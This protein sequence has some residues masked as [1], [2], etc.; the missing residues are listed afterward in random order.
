MH[1]YA[2]PC[3]FCRLTWGRVAVV[4]THPAANADVPRRS[5]QS[6]RVPAE[7]LE[8]C[9]RSR[10]LWA[11]MGLVMASEPQAQH[12][13]G[14]SAVVGLDSDAGLRWSYWMKLRRNAGASAASGVIDRTACVGTYARTG[15][16]PHPDTRGTRTNARRYTDTRGACPRSGGPHGRTTHATSGN[17][18]GRAIRRCQG[19]R[20]QQQPPCR[21]DQR[22]QDGDVTSHGIAWIRGSILTSV[23]PRKSLAPATVTLP[24]VSEVAI[25]A[26]EV[27]FDR[28][29]TAR[30][31]ANP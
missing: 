6:K 11:W 16:W 29:L 24:V 22:G 23:L 26:A 27:G 8:D 30:P 18:S 1:W 3:S 7:A 15:R 2:H 10:L 5:N 4:C 19:R 20:S 31:L 12:G 17:A 21:R 13:A 14:G 9:D 28:S 25:T